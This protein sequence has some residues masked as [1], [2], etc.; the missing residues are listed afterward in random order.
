MSQQKILI[1]EDDPTLLDLLKYN[2]EKEGYIT[3]KAEDGVKALEAARS[4]QPDFIILDLMLPK[5]SGFEVCRILRQ[6]MDVPIMMLT[7]KEDEIDKVVGL[8][9]G[10]DDY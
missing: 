8:D 6:E 5:M 10:A 3:I 2:L 1:V 4:S 9:L 7:A